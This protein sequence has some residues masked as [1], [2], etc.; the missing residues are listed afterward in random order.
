MKI[1]RK[2]GKYDGLIGGLGGGGGALVV[3]PVINIFLQPEYYFPERIHPMTFGIIL[4]E[5]V[6]S[7]L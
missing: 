1:R 5:M 3:S 2:K 4:A 7:L 6:I